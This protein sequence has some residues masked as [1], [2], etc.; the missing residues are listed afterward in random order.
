MRAGARR[1]SPGAPLAEAAVAH[2]RYVLVLGVFS[3]HGDGGSW[4]EQLLPALRRAFYGGVRRHASYP[5]P[6]PPRRA[7]TLR[8]WGGGAAGVAATT[9]PAGAEVVGASA[10]EEQALAASGELAVLLEN[11]YINHF[12]L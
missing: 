7:F 12:G 5:R 4:G 8:W 1:F 2:G 3:A 6:L 11:T 9:G 10:N